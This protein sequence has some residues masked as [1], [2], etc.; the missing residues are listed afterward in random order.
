M[1][2]DSLIRYKKV[3]ENNMK[4]TPRNGTPWATK[5][6]FEPGIV[7]STAKGLF[8]LGSLTLAG[9]QNSADLTYKA[10]QNYDF[11]EDFQHCIPKAVD[12]QTLGEQEHDCAEKIFDEKKE[13]MDSLFKEVEGL[14]RNRAEK[15]PWCSKD[16]NKLI[17]SQ[18]RFNKFI[19]NNSKLT[20]MAF[21]RSYPYNYYGT[22]VD[23]INVRMKH[24]K[25]LMN[26]M[27]DFK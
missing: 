16:H 18:N 14:Y 11:T 17:T 2:L 10:N 9:C 3:W 22:M 24:L 23:Y 21:A 12:G 27:K 20:N 7:R 26:E 6:I 5:S 19:K 15:S 25:H 4:I 8:V 1:K 13:Q